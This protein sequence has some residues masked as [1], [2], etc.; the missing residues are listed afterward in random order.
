MTLASGDHPFFG[1]VICAIAERPIVKT[2]TLII[3]VLHN[4]FIEVC[5]EINQKHKQFLKMKKK[6]SG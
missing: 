4:A 2:N 1:R 6:A 3:E 5:N